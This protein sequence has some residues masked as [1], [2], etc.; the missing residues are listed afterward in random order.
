MYIALKWLIGLCSAMWIIMCCIDIYLIKTKEIQGPDANPKT[1]GVVFKNTSI[2]VEP[3]TRIHV[4]NL[5][6]SNGYRHQSMAVL[7]YIMF[8]AGAFAVCLYNKKNEI[9]SYTK[10]FVYKIN[11]YALLKRLKKAAINSRV[12]TSKFI[13]SVGVN[14]KEVV[15]K[16]I[17]DVLLLN[18]K[19]REYQQNIHN[20]LLQKLKEVG[21]ERKNL[22]QLLIAAI[23]ENKTIRVQYQLESMAKN[24]LLRHMDDTQKKIKEN[25]SRYVSFQHLYLVTHQENIF[26]KARLRKLTLAKEEAEKNLLGLINEVYKTKNTKLRKY[27]SRFI[28]RTNDNLLNSDVNAEIQKFL[29]NPKRCIAANNSY[30]QLLTQSKFSINS[31]NSFPTG[32]SPHFTE[33]TILQ[34]DNN[35]DHLA[36]DAPRL[37][38]LPGEYVWTVKDKDGIIEKLYEYDYES[39]FD[40]GDTIRRIRQYSVYFDKDCLLD[41]TNSRTIIRETAG[42]GLQS[43]HSTMNYPK[44]NERF[45]TGSE[46]FKTFLRDNNNIIPT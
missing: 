19:R 30:C 15:I 39:D 33:N 38:G 9:I 3:L 40:T 45:L 11:V 32:T 16:L 34:K 26:L 6:I 14:I 5:K 35:L 44:A 8:L 4:E 21:E 17:R 43:A 29:D 7:H 10:Y 31:T 24:R 22:G 27:C 20:L 23:H 1:F 18:I 13:L 25:R 28:D 12:A 36:S 46:I 2:P 42:P 37:K 41:F